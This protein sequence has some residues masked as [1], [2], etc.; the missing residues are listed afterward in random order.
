MVI[1]RGAAALHEINP[2]STTATTLR[3]EISDV[4][5]DTHSRLDQLEKVNHI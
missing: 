2:T 5:K 3:S 4:F 1:I